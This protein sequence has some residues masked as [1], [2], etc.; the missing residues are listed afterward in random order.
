MSDPLDPQSLRRHIGRTVRHMGM[1][2]RVVEV[3]DDGPALVLQGADAVIQANRFGD[4][5]RRVPHTY[6]V[7]VRDAHGDPHPDFLALH[8]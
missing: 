7:P 8:L 1:A 6:T 5:H 3:L 4:A 2:C